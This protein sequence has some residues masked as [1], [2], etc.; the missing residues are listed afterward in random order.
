MLDRF[1]QR[2][3]E[4]LLDPV[5]HESVGHRHLKGLSLPLIFEPG[6]LIEPHGVPPLADRPGQLLGKARN[7]I[8]LECDSH[9]RSFRA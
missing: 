2:L 1:A 6:G 5:G 7:L 3:A 4:V 9:D 8:V